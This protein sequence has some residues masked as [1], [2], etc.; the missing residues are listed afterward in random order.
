MKIQES[1]CP[2]CGNPSR[3]GE[4]CSTC[5]V[6]LTRWMECE[7]RIKSIECPVCGARKDAGIWT[8][9]SRERTEIATE[10]I[11]QS[12]RLHPD[13][14]SPSYDIRIT[15]VSTNRSVAQCAVTAMLYGLPVEGNCRIEIAWVREQCDRCN[16][17]SGS[18]YEGVV[19]VRASG[20]KPYPEE[21]EAAAR[22]ALEVE[23]ALIENGERLSFISSIDPSRD[24]LDVTIGSQHIGQEISNAIVQR[25]GGRYTTHPKLVGEKA[26]KQL[27]RIT[28]SLRLPH[29]RRGDVIEIRGRYGEVM[30]TEGQNVRYTELPSGTS[31][32]VRED[33]VIRLVGNAKDAADY[34]VAYH[35]AGI[36]GILNPA[37]GITVECQ[38]GKWHGVEPGQYIRALR[39]GDNLILLGV[40]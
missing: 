10:M 18:Y 34:L 25:L 36:I 15:D 33:D 38:A 17:L 35:D 12:I 19:Q 37:D 21:I 7:P 23:G 14:K 30:A 16:R 2:R 9:N 1:I 26:G 13:V 24:G 11:Y 31:K 6:G 27:F 39:D 29:F 3:P 28:Y 4:L 5:R 20:R 8:D 32:T 40:R 22:I